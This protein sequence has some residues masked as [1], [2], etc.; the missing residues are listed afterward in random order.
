MKIL[1][2][3]LAAFALSFRLSPVHDVFA[4]PA[5]ATGTGSCAMPPTAFT[6]DQVRIVG[7]TPE[8]PAVKE[9]LA[10]Y[11]DLVQASN[12]HSIE[13]ILKHYNPQF[14]KSKA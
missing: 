10:N 1:K 13:D 4:A 9:L 14:R 7:A 11:T 12:R 6:A 2:L 8:T 5:T 3:S